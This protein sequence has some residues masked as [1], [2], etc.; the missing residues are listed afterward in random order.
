[1][2]IEEKLVENGTVIPGG[3]QI[4]FHYPTYREPETCKIIMLDRSVGDNFF[5]GRF[6]IDR[7]FRII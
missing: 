1:M 3:F 7:K 5:F 6:P 4:K 2:F